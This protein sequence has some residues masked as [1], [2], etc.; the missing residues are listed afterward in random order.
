MRKVVKKER[1]ERGR[2]VVRERRLMQRLPSVNPTAESVVKGG[3]PV[4]RG[5]CVGRWIPV[6]WVGVGVDWSCVL[7]LV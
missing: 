3:D 1:I 5:W 4:S 7:D 6:A 2:V